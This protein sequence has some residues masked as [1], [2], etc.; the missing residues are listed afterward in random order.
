MEP[1]VNRVAQSG[2][3]VFDLTPFAPDRDPVVLDL[4]PFL[5]GGLVLREKPF[6]EAVAAL[7][8]EAYRGRVVALGCSA[9]ALVPAWAWM[10]V[11]S[12]LDG[13]ARS[14]TLGSA[15]DAVREH[16]LAALEAFDWSRYDDRIVVVKG[17]GNARVPEA[18]YVMAMSRLQRVA[19]KVMFGEPCSSVPLWRRPAT[20]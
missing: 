12:R 11:A 20:S 14:V 1:I 13:V 17:C 4:E 3:E 5:V 7:D 6:R 8:L 2:I 9:D 15:D 10:L 19:R 16:V 18:A